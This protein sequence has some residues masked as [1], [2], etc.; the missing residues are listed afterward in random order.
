MVQNIKN[1]LRDIQCSISLSIP[2]D[3]AQ[4]L[5]ETSSRISSSSKHHDSSNRDFD[6]MISECKTRTMRKKIQE[7][8]ANEP[9]KRSQMIKPPQIE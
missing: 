2:Q 1:P 3:Y 7:L 5:N 8:K 6:S 9:S 4:T